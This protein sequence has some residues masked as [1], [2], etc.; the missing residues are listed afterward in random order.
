MSEVKGLVRRM[1]PNEIQ[2]ARLADAIEHTVGYIT[3]PV[4][5]PSG[6][7]ALEI[8][9]SGMPRNM[10]PQE[11]ERYAARLRAATAVVMSETK[12]RIP[13]SKNQIG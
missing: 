7:V 5:S 11:I 13:T 10:S 2:L 12:G 9:I 4:F 8:A 3:A 1:S 6:E